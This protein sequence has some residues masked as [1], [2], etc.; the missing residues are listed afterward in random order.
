MSELER[1]GKGS[2]DDDGRRG[3][4]RL[5][6]IQ[7]EEV[8]KAGTIRMPPPT[9]A[10]AAMAP[11]QAP[12]MSAVT[13][14]FMKRSQAVQPPFSSACDDADYQLAKHCFVVERS[15]HEPGVGFKASRHPLPQLIAGESLY[16]SGSEKQWVGADLPLLCPADP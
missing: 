11:A 16:F 10:S 15:C 4:D 13:S 6:M 3:A 9:P 2:D 7:V 5:L 14:V 8:L 1:D 12:M